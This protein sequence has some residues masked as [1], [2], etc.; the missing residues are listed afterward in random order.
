MRE[1]KPEFTQLLVASEAV[2]TEKLPRM[3]EITEQGSS[4]KKRT[5]SKR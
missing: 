1:T 4:L 5:A 2:R 3:G